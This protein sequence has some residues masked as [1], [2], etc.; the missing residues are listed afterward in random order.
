MG[1]LA[2]VEFFLAASRNRRDHVEMR[3]QGRANTQRVWSE[4]AGLH[5]DK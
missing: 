1:E 5:I 4:F 2:K 3:D